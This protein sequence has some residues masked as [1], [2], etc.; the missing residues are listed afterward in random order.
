MAALTDVLSRN[1]VRVS[2]A[3]FIELLEQSLVEFGGPALD[4]PASALSAD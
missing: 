1:H 4:D 3:R 2:E